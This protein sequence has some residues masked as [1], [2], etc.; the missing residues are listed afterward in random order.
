VKNLRG[1]Q[2]IIK[3]KGTS[4]M[5][6]F[7][8][9]VGCGLHW[10]SVCI[11]LYHSTVTHTE[12][13]FLIHSLCYWTMITLFKSC[14]M[15]RIDKKNAYKK[16]WANFAPTTLVLH[17]KLKNASSPSVHPMPAPPELLNVRVCGIQQASFKTSL[18]FVDPIAYYH[19]LNFS[20]FDVKSKEHSKP[21]SKIF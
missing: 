15:G 19:L 6:Y 3:K 7:L 8:P 4:S 10:G 17:I 2:V 12:R 9:L 18:R 1:L 11:V 14:P 13:C 21:N 20:K 5:F 16:H